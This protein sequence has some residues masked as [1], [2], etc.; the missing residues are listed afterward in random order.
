MILK[1]NTH[2]NEYV[3]SHNINRAFQLCRN[4]SYCSHS[5]VSFSE[6]LPTAAAALSVLQKCFPLQPQHCQFC[7]NA[8]LRNGWR[9]FCSAAPFPQTSTAS[10]RLT[11]IFQL[12]THRNEHSFCALAAVLLILIRSSITWSG[13]LAS[14]LVMLFK[15]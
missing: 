1:P 10:V 8:S 13:S 11:I 14:F 7:R 12:N 3:C 4:A 9:H 5:T 15:I 6:M 2:R